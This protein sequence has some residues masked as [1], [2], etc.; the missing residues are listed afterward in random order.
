ME[1]RA[2]RPELMLWLRGVSI[3][4]FWLSVLL[5]DL[6]WESGRNGQMADGAAPD[7]KQNDP[8]QDE[9]QAETCPQ[10]KGSPAT[11]EAEPVPQWQT[12]DPIRGEVAEH[13]RARV[14]CASKRSGRNCLNAIE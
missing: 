10:A 13:G 14:A 6:G 12:D 4:Q 2:L 9:R 7:E 5:T 8:D 11:A 3:A 1:R